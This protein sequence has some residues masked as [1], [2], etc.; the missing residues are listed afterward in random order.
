MKK[1]K[2]QLWK[3]YF[4]LAEQFEE[5]IKKVQGVQLKYEYLQNLGL[6]NNDD[7]LNKIGAEMKDIFNERMTLTV[8][9]N[10]VVPAI[11]GNQ[12]FQMN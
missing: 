9:F 11:I 2:L 8:E 12:N 10:N 6:Q 7:E 5:L 3:K 1:E 4:D